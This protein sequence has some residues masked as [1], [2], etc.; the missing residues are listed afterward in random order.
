[1]AVAP[2][3]VAVLTSGGVLSLAML[4]DLAKKFKT[5][6]PIYVVSGFI[7]EPA[8]RFWLRRFHRHLKRRHNS[9]GELID[10]SFP[11]K[12]IYRRGYW[13]TDGGEVPGPYAAD[14]TMELP[15]HNLTLLTVAS[16]FCN[17]NGIREL[18]IGTLGS[19]T[20][21]D[22]SAEFYKQFEE[23]TKLG[24]RKRVKILTPLS[25]AKRSNLIK[26]ADDLPL[27]QTFSCI[28]PKGQTHCGNCY[29]CGERKRAFQDAGVKD[30][31]QYEKEG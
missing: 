3:T 16:V 26:K 27:D 28:N 24:L 29:K 14:S 23:L 11:I 9:M 2:D 5:V 13:A 30:P 31:T 25:H 12:T 15:G 7:W 17:I 20:F 8:E 21:S 19:S 6:I 1:M 22:A 10:I 4:E 18:A